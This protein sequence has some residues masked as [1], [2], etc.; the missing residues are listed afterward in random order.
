MAPRP[1]KSERLLA[2]SSW[3]TRRSWRL[4][5]LTRSLASADSTSS[6]RTSRLSTLPRP[7]KLDGSSFIQGSQLEAVWSW[8][9]TLKPSVAQV[10]LHGHPADQPLMENQDNLINGIFMKDECWAHTGEPCLAPTHAAWTTSFTLEAED[11]AGNKCSVPVSYPINSTIGASRLG[12]SEETEAKLAAATTGAEK[13]EIAAA[14]EGSAYAKAVSSLNDVA[15]QAGDDRPNPTSSVFCRI[16]GMINGEGLPSQQLEQ[17]EADQAVISQFSSWQNEI[18]V[19]PAHNSTI[20]DILSKS[21]RHSAKYNT[22]T[23]VGKGN[24]GRVVN[25]FGGS[26]IVLMLL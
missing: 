14:D 13:H 11:S 12:F 6:S 4:R 1:G 3:S 10:D 16:M 8:C 9:N 15:N 22:Q 2:L 19:Y 23:V 18:G 17:Y 26:L 5:A 7:K 25:C 20:S 24:F 21:N